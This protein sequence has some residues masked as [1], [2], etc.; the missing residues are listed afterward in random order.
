[1]RWGIYAQRGREC[2]C[3]GRCGYITLAEIDMTKKPYPTFQ[4]IPAKPA[5]KSQIPAIQANGPR[6]PFQIKEKQTD[7]NDTQTNP[8]PKGGERVKLAIDSLNSTGDKVP[9]EIGDAGGEDHH[10]LGGICGEPR[11]FAKKT[12]SLSLPHPCS[13]QTLHRTTCSNWLRELIIL[14]SVLPQ[15]GPEPVEAP[16]RPAAVLKAEQLD[17]PARDSLPSPNEPQSLP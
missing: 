3:V 10:D 9:A 8:I 5:R 1:M 17:A 7:E 11:H 12:I 15:H 2:S 6:Y 16:P 4:G 14:Y 13:S